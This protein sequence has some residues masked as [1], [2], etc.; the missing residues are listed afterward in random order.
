MKAVPIELMMQGAGVL[1]RHRACRLDSFRAITSGHRAA[2]KAATDFA[3][4]WPQPAPG[5]SLIFTG[6]PGTGKTHLACAIVAELLQSRRRALYMTMHRAIRRVRDTW[7]KGSEKSASQAIEELV[8]P[9]LLVLDE[10]CPATEFEREL[11]FEV[12][13]ERYARRKPY[14]LATNV[15]PQSLAD[16]IDER[17]LDRMREDGGEIV[18]FNWASHRGNM[19]N[20]REST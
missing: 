6:P 4:Q 10:F 5:K 7:A 20:T 19:A 12:L 2:L 3:Q 18:T 9:A 15:P 13:N 8:D 11:I 14:I 16:H 1:E 17:T